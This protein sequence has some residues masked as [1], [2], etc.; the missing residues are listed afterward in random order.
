M[1]GVGLLYGVDLRMSEGLTSQLNEVFPVVY[2]SPDNRGADVA[3]EPM[4]ADG[5]PD[6]PGADWVPRKIP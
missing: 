6:E 5:L 1:A 4:A 3:A 2:R